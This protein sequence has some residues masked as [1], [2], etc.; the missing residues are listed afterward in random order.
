MNSWLLAKAEGQRGRG[1]GRGQSN[2][3]SM[4]TLEQDYRVGRLNVREVSLGDDC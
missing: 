3:A 4:E 1:A 2:R